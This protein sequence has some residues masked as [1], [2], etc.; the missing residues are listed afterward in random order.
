MAKVTTARWP[1]YGLSSEAPPR[2][3]S[4]RLLDGDGALHERRMDRA[5]VAI[6]AGSVESDRDRLADQGEAAVGTVVELDVV[7]RLAVVRESNRVAGADRRISRVQVVSAFHRD[8]LTASAC[9]LRARSCR[10]WSC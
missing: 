7:V 4:V 3:R 10:R 1:D 8:G 5:H 9:F 2:P 6:R